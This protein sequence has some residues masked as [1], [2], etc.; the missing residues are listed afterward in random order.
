MW[1]D[2][3]KDEDFSGLS[4]SPVSLDFTTSDRVPCRTPIVQNT[5]CWASR[6][7]SPKRR[8]DFIFWCLSPVRKKNRNVTKPDSGRTGFTRSFLFRE[9][10]HGARKR[11]STSFRTGPWAPGN[12]VERDED[13]TTERRVRFDG[14]TDTGTR[15]RRTSPGDR[16][17]L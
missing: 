12:T 7:L 13:G 17:N 1:N 11:P 16:D 8:T 6:C 2:T 3:N 5:Q 9:G 15:S 14:D 10:L 4:F